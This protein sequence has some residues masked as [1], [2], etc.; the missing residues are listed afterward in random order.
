MHLRMPAGAFGR[1]G[2]EIPLVGGN[3]ISPMRCVRELVSIAADYA[4]LAFAMDRLNR[5]PG[6]SPSRRSRLCELLGR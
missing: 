1:C 6:L 4:R 3:T 5:L 2:P